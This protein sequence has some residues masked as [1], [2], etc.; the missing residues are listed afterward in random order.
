MKAVGIIVEYNPFHNGHLYQINKVKE[1][2]PEYPLIVVMSGYFT[3][4]GEPSI[5][6]KWDKTKIA[7][8]YGVD[9]VI[10]L[11]FPFATQSADI[12]AKGAVEILNHLQVEYLVFGS[13]D[14]NIEKLIKLANLQINNVTYQSKVKQWLLE[15]ENYPTAISKA[16]KDISNETISTPNDL[17]G[18]SYIKELIKTNSNIIPLSIKRTNDYHNLELTASISSA[19]SIRKGLREGI[20]ITPYVPTYN[21]Y[22]YKE[23]IYLG[24]NYFSLLKY[25]IICEGSNLVNYQTVDEGIENRLIKEI[26]KYNNLESFLLGIKTKR[27][28]YQ[29]LNRMCTHILCGFT[30]AYASQFNHIS[31]LRILGF[32][33]KGQLYLNKIKNSLTIPLITKV[34]SSNDPMLLYETKVAGVYGCIQSNNTENFKDLEYKQKPIR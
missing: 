30:K 9:L 12:F 19:S 18:L 14:N 34:A 6:S 11:P 29:R 8:N 2:F 16:L 3:E 23:N 21:N 15:G 4:R 13:E 32:S 1:M 22:I 28:T 26:G 10:E 17:L 20:D 7:I 5:I 27:Y 25:K 24:E 31:Y 33:K